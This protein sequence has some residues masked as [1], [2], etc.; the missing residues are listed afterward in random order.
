VAQSGALHR[1]ACA[2]NATTN[3]IKAEDMTSKVRKAVLPVAGLGTRF[4]PATKAVPKEMLPIVDRPLIDY[5]VAEA[6]AA[7]I[8]T[9]IFVTNQRNEP[10]LRAHFDMVATLEAELAA[11][12]PALV[13]RLRDGEPP[14]GSIHCVPQGQPLGLGHAVGC[15][16]DLVGDEPFAVILPDDLMD[17]VPPALAQMVAVHERTGGNV[18]AVEEVPRELTRRYGV[19]DIGADD[20]TMAEVKGLV[21]KPEPEKAPSTLTVIGRYVLL[22]EVF[23]HIAKAERGAGGEIQLTDAMAKMIGRAPFHGLRCGGRRF[24]CG[25][26]I[27]FVE[28]QVGFGLKDPELRDRLMQFLRASGS[29]WE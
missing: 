9:F 10:T 8:E 6:R 11:K 16:R 22:P 20:G 23:E 18:V 1:A 26:R 21:E 15:A 19:L 28:A 7:G 3:R 12:D 24:D 29:E 14:K 5:A 27:G 4:L 17:A 2:V 13:R 25:S